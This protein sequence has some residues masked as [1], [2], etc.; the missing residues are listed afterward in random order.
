MEYLNDLIRQLTPEQARTFAKECAEQALVAVNNARQAAR[1]TDANPYGP[2]RLTK[3]EEYLELA[4]DYASNAQ[5]DNAIE[6]ALD[7]SD[8]AIA[9]IAHAH[10]KG[11]AALKAVKAEGARQKAVLLAHLG[12][13]R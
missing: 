11:V 2:K 7:T 9:A 5:D 12:A 6:A 8:Y 3:A 10:A 1:F 13:P 4:R